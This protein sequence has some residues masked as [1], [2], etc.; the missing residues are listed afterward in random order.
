MCFFG[1]VLAMARILGW[2]YGLYVALWAV[3]VWRVVTAFCFF[4]HG[5]W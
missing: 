5:I 2:F 3:G 1:V 4:T